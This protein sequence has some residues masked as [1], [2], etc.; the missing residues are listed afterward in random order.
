[1]VVSHM[2]GAGNSFVVFNNIMDS[3]PLEKLRHLA[4]FLCERKAAGLPPAEGVLILQDADLVSFRADFLNP[5]GSYGPMCG[6]G[7]RCIVRYATDKLML[8]NSDVGGSITFILSGNSYIAHMSESE[9]ITIEF[10]PPVD[11]REWPAGTLDGVG[12]AVTY[13]NIN[14]DHCVVDAREAGFSSDDFWTFDIDSLAYGLRHHRSFP[15]GAN[16]NFFLPITNHLVALRTFE[17]GVERE[18]GA[19]GTGALCTALTCFKRG[20]TGTEVCIEPTS[21]RMLDISLLLDFAH[22]SEYPMPYK[23]LLTGDAKYDAEDSTFSLDLIC[24]L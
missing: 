15:R 14:S 22:V 20:L 19:C 16:V 5:D 24:Y 4:P 6:N 9:K 23:L 1:M 13:V 17:R 2:S 8:D 12:F 18:T 11:Y 3:L 7:A 10:A 21:H